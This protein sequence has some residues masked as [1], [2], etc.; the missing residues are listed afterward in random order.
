M[1]EAATQEAQVTSDNWEGANL[2]CPSRATSCL[3]TI[4]FVLFAQKSFLI[5]FLFFLNQRNTGIGSSLW[6]FISDELSSIFTFI[7]LFFFF[8]GQ[9]S[10]KCS[11]TVVVFPLSME[12]SER[13]AD[14]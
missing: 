5:L 10:N 11:L 12:V 13:F 8:S 7:D 14:E 2:S 9:E 3:S 6:S 1:Q 4:I